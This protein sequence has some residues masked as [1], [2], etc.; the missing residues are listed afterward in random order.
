MLRTSFDAQHVHVEVSD[1][2]R[3]VDP[4]L[5]ERIFDSFVTGKEGGL[6]MGLSISRTIV[7]AH[8]GILRYAANPGGGSTFMFSLDRADNR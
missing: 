4:A 1:T 5:A 6:G 3:G 8:G 2:G 7:E